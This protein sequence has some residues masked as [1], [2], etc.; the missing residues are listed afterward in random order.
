MLGA[1]FVIG[2]VAPGTGQSLKRFSDNHG[3]KIVSR[4]DALAATHVG[5]VTLEDLE[6]LR[7]PIHRVYLA[8][9]LTDVPK[10]VQRLT[11]RAREAIKDC[12][13]QSRYA[14]YSVYDPFNHTRPGS[15]HSPDEIFAINFFE[16]ATADLV[17]LCRTAP[18]DGVGIE[19][20]VALNYKVPTLIIHPKERRLSRLLLAEPGIHIPPIAFDGIP[21]LRQDLNARMQEIALDTVTERTH[22]RHLKASNWH[23]SFRRMIIK[24]RIRSKITRE[25]L[26]RACRIGT[27]KLKQI[28]QHD[29]IV[30]GLSSLESQAILQA[31]GS[32]CSLRPGNGIT[33]PESDETDE[34]CDSIHL[35]HRPAWK[36]SLESIV[37]FV[38]NDMPSDDDRVLQIWG[39]YDE[40]MREA[41]AGRE[42]FAAPLTVE[43][44]R[45]QYDTREPRRLL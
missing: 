33:L 10:R 22:R 36:E 15:K 43:Q 14:D 37:D 1:S 28:E 12:F 2:P 20:N 5:L 26:A 7:R 34:F 3:V 40:M 9:P 13:I 41:V 39:G 30:V 31:L 11:A 38:M 18:A 27:G 29:E 4:T 42:S 32:R 25:A 23:S 6:P 24:L 45:T 17:V 8:S 19:Y 35:V 16:I 44:W 21:D